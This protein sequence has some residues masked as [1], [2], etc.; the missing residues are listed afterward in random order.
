MIASRIFLAVAAL[1]ITLASAACGDDPPSRGDV[2]ARIRADPQMAGA[3]D[4]TVNCIAD[5]YDKY[6]TDEMRSAFKAGAAID[7]TGAGAGAG[8]EAAMLDCIKLA[9]QIR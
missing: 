3:D 4:G 8:A 6:A 7:L 2:V 1:G 9:T 5:W